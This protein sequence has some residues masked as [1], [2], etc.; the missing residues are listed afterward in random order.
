MDADYLEVISKLTTH[1]GDIVN[2]WTRMAI[3]YFAA[4]KGMVG[5]QFCGVA[6][7]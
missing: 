5:I 4:R 2:K 1:V 6:Y 3:L 7:K